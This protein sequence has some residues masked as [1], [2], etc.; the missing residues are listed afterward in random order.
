MPTRKTSKLKSGGTLHYLVGQEGM[1]RSSGTLRSYYITILEHSEEAAGRYC[2]CALYCQHVWSLRRYHVGLAWMSA[3][4]V[5][6]SR[7]LRKYMFTGIYI[8][9]FF[10]KDQYL[11]LK[12]NHVYMLAHWNVAPVKPFCISNLQYIRTIFHVVIRQENSCFC[13]ADSAGW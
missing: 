1:L 2:R 9:I 5:V 8:Y 6:L 11:A 7:K 4:S 12:T 13:C 3:V 10:L